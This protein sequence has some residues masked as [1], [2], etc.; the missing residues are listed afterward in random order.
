[1]SRG[2]QVFLSSYA[3][4]WGRRHQFVGHVFQGRSTNAELVAVLGVSRP[5][6]I[7]NLSRCFQQRLQSSTEVSEQ[8]RQIEQMLGVPSKIGK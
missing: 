2:L 3:N 1:M 8:L 7:P 4:V 6:S 5:E